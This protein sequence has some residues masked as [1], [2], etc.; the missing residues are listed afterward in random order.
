M[1][2]TMP[3]AVGL[4]TMKISGLT[5]PIQQDKAVNSSP[6]ERELSSTADRKSP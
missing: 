5:A 3:D 1:H 2:G 4:E 6:F